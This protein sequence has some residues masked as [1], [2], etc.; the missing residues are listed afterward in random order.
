MPMISLAAARVNA[1]LTQA[2]VASMLCV[3]KSTVVKWEKGTTSPRSN[4]LRALC[5]LYNMPMDYIFLPD[6]LLKVE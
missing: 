6:S 2:E 1:R 5:D 3:S 4:Q